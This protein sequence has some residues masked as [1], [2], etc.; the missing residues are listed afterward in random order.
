MNIVYL[1][2]EFL[3]RAEAKISVMDRAFLFADGIYEVIPIYQGKL[4]RLSEHLKRL[5]Y[6][7]GEIRLAS[8]HTDAEWEQLFNQ[9]IQRNGGG[10][11]SLY[12]QITRGCAPIR[13]HAFPKTAVE[14]TVFM[15]VSPMAAPY[16][17]DLNREQGIK[18]VCLA[19]IRWLRCDIK[20]VSLLP[21]ALLRQ[22]ALDQGVDEA[23]L[24]RDGNV[25]EGA[26]SNIFI[27]KDNALITPPR[28]QFILG[29]IT[30]DL[31]IELAQAHQLDCVE[32]NI[33]QAELMT[34]DEVWMT[35]STKEIAPITQVDGKAIGTGKVGNVWRTV[36]GWY[37]DY[38]QT[39]LKLPPTPSS[40]E[41]GEPS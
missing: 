37:N 1:N 5:A 41:E 26:A 7:L 18:A 21:N 6:S 3:P 13:D 35:S 8:P 11:I 28:N 17:T 22:Q 27:V 20:S 29:G 15:M 9:L 16:S 33:T 38:K 25:T 19:D 10:N 32:K 4:F 40:T 31:I 30:R 14:P 23:I 39:L 34:A 36:A 24:I 12:L 2:G